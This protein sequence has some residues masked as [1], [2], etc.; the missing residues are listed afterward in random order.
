MEVFR[1]DTH[2]SELSTRHAAN[3]AR[4][5]ETRMLVDSRHMQQSPGKLNLMSVQ[6][7]ALLGLGLIVIALKAGR[8]FIV[9]PCIVHC[10]VVDG[11]APQRSVVDCIVR[12]IFGKMDHGSSQFSWR[13]SKVIQ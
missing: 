11:N 3:A 12:R 6:I 5:S 4:P 8:Y 2:V 10:T 1:P 7:C 13:S 9:D